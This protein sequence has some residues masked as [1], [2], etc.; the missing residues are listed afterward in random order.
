MAK[1]GFC[2]GSDMLLYV[3]EKAIGSCTTHTTTF[4]SETKERAVKPVA[5]KAI[6]SGLWKK[7][8][9]MKPSAVLRNCLRC[10]KQESRYR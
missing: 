1:S 2:N 10:G 5:S 9:M 8:G 6:S 3:G 7:K 4:S